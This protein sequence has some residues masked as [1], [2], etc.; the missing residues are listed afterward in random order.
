MLERVVTRDK[1]GAKGLRQFQAK[2]FK[3]SEAEIYGKYRQHENMCKCHSITA[4][5][6]THRGT[7]TDGS[8]HG[9][10][11]KTGLQVSD[12]RST[13]FNMSGLTSQQP[14]RGV[15]TKTWLQLGETPLELPD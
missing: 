12:E 9:T 15:E 3:W 14:I 11:P 4:P 5:H 8:V 1:W 10:L 7:H 6:Q 2:Q 13:G